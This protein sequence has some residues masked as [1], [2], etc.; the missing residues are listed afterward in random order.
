MWV[1]GTWLSVW[2][3]REMEEGVPLPIIDDSE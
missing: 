2:L 3:R 1:G